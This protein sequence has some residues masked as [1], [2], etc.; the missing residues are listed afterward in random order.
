LPPEVTRE[1][2]RHGAVAQSSGL[3]REYVAICTATSR[4]GGAI[5]LSVNRATPSSDEILEVFKT[6]LTKDSF[7]LCDGAKSY[8]T[9]EK[10]GICGVKCINVPVAGEGFENINTTNGFHSLIKARIKAAR[11]VAT[12]YQNRY[13]AMFE[14]IYRNAKNVSGE[15]W[16]I[17]KRAGARLSD[18]KSLSTA[19]VLEI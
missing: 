14:K 4:D 2:R 8:N 9:L 6:R 18:T 17:A 16:N 1:P 11:G 15:I 7:V 13:N 12:K 10:N 5:A 3:S 19:G